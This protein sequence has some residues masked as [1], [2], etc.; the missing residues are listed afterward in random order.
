M[1]MNSWR[2]NVAPWSQIRDYL[3]DG[4]EIM[5]REYYMLVPDEGLLDG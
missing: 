3:L 5:E 1:R 2:E 4:N